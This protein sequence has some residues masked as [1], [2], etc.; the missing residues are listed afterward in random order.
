MCSVSA[1]RAAAQRDHV[2]QLQHQR[3]VGTQQVF[4]AFHVF[5]LVL[6]IAR[7]E[8]GDGLAV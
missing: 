4:A 2:A 5:Y 1:P 3:R 8:L 6:G 7:A